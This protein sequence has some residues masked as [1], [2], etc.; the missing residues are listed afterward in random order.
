MSTNKKSATKSNSNRSSDKSTKPVTARAPEKKKT[1]PAK[2]GGESVMKF[3]KLT[4]SGYKGHREGS[5]KE[6]AHRLFDKFGKDAL[7]KIT[8]LKIKESTARVWM[9]TFARRSSSSKRSAA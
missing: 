2:K 5:R 9:S 7:P 8:A 6:K 1:V 3:K 4:G